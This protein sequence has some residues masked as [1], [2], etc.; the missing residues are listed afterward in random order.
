MIAYRSI[1]I[2]RDPMDV[3]PSIRTGLDTADAHARL[4]SYGLL[5][6]CRL[7]L[8][9]GRF[10]IVFQQLESAAWERCVYVFAIADEIIRIGSCKSTLKVRM[11]AWEWSVSKRFRGMSSSTPE[12][13]AEAWREMLSHWG[14][15][16]VYA[17][18]GT[19]VETPV[20]SFPCYLDEESLLI[21]RHRPAL[22]RHS[23]R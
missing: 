2:L 4:T 17:R 5:P 7:S 3:K 11:K 14:E 21:G 16:F 10:S 8:D 15:G 19:V 9:A 23:H 22:N 18:Q 12:W 6:V 20:G 1:G 13:E